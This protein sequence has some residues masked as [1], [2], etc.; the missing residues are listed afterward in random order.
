MTQALPQVCQLSHACFR[1]LGEPVFRL[2]EGTRVASMVV[3]LQNQEAVLPLRA[4]AREFGVEAASADGQML[5]LIEQALDFVVALR[6]GDKLPS[7]LNGGEASWKPSEQDRRIATSRIWHALLRCVFTHTGQS[8]AISGAGSPGWEES[9]ANREWLSRAIDGAVIQLDGPDAP[10]ITACLASLSEELACIET[11]RRS[12]ARGMAAPQEKLLRIPATKLPAGRRETMV[13]VQALMRRG[14]KEITYRFDD[15]DARL[16]DFMAMLRDTP[17][18]IV[19]MRR[20]R[21]W[22]FRTKLAWEPVFTDWM[23]APSAID[24]FL[25]KAVERSYSFLA[26]RFMSFQEWSAVDAKPKQPMRATVW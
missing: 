13:H 16:D 5:C 8:V 2:S 10:E 25:W 22:L 14:L 20:Q 9:S 11:M 4:V 21:D 23:N 6:L 15:V 1:M 19:W 24:E 18:A 3:R 26:P 12:L 7:E 17:A